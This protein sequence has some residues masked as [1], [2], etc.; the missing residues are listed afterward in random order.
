MPLHTGFI[1]KWIGEWQHLDTAY[2]RG[3]TVMK[4]AKAVGK[5]TNNIVDI[6]ATMP[7]EV[8]FDDNMFFEVADDSDPVEEA[9]QQE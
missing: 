5:L 6:E 1:L 2:K 3:M 4:L 8:Y 9:V 7:A